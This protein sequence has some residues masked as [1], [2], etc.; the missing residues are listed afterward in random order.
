[1]VLAS[2]G[3]PE[4]PK[5]GEHIEGLDDARAVAG[6]RVYAAGVVSNRSP[7]ATALWLPAGAG[8]STWSGSASRPGR[9]RAE[10]LTRRPSMVSWPGMVSPF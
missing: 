10:L 4:R 7:A 9:A 6:A 2:P 8:C 5:T 1:M 3:Y